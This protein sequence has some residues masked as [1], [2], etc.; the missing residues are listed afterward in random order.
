M[1]RVSGTASVQIWVREWER[2]DAGV[3]I[4]RDVRGCF[5]EGVVFGN[6]IR[7]LGTRSARAGRAAVTY[8]KAWKATVLLIRVLCCL[9]T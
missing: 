2:G 1:D 9:E 8:R 4:Q 6:V 7:K 5:V 3:E